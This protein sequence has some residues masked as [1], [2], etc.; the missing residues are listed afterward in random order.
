MDQLSAS[1]KKKVLIVEDESVV[2]L[3][4]RR[5]L[6]SLGYHVVGCAT[7]GNRAI[8][9]IKNEPP[10]V[11]LMDIK[12]KGD[13]DGLDTARLV[14]NQW[15]IPVVYVTAYAD[16]ETIQRAKITNSFGYVLKPFQDR[17]ISV[18]VEMA[19]F[20]H[21]MQQEL[22]EARIRAE[23]ADR[24][25]S[26]FLA[27]ISHELRTPL[28]SI[29]GMA[30]LSIDMCENSLQQDY[31]VILRK[32]AG[33]LLDIINNILSFI[34]YNSDEIAVENVRYDFSGLLR[35]VA[36]S[37]YTK[38]VEKGLD[39]NIWEE[40][41]VNSSLI[42]DAQKLWQILFVLL[43]N[44]VKFTPAGSIEFGI[45]VKETDPATAELN[46]IIEDT[47]IGIQGDDLERIFE[48]FTQGD[49]S[50]T[51]R[52]SGTGIGL[53]LAKS[54]LTRL[55]GSIRVESEQGAGTTF[56]IKLPQGYS[57]ELVV[58]NP[59]MVPAG[60]R[61]VI[62][63][64][65]DR[66]REILEQYLKDAG[67]TAVS[68]RSFPEILDK[69]PSLIKNNWVCLMHADQIN[70]G[71]FRDFI[72]TRSPKLDEFIKSARF[73]IMTKSGE[74]DLND[75]IERGVI[76]ERLKLPILRKDLN[77]AILRVMSRSTDEKK[78]ALSF[79]I[80]RTDNPLRILLVEDNAINRLVNSKMLLR[81]GHFVSVAE[82]GIQALDMLKKEKYE[83]VLMDIQMPVMDGYETTKKIRGGAEKNIPRDIPIVALT[84]HALEEEEQKSMAA[85]M[86]GFLTKPFTPE[87][88]EK[89]L[90]KASKGEPVFNTEK[91][92]PAGSEDFYK[93]LENAENQI[94]EEAWSVLKGTLHELKVLGA[95]IPD[96][97][98]SIQEYI[99]RFQL[100]IR[101]RNAESAM[102]L[103][104]NLKE[105]VQ[106]NNNVR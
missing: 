19:I 47:G 101:K 81:M 24:M 96:D 76:F 25:K 45:S 66:Q 83:L 95:N 50:R 75:Y 70:N 21:Q 84:A 106:K 54:L 67:C 15:D 68:C 12:L 63:S 17:E 35:K 2:A 78:Q 13:I 85:G 60:T 104:T 30:D 49:G 23:A 58:S 43:D 97:N 41:T 80:I 4:I 93:K 51:R 53:A 99:F 29:I 79:S 28:N 8:E 31:L 72:S 62:I 82:N 27:N 86:N 89:T 92:S 59:P 74:G 1:S 90:M 39:F 26:D 22:N 52:F 9:F 69:V 5:R 34:K 32:S 61:G 91:Q 37:V 46:F 87:N 88:L 3:D 103:L 48:P 102:E 33:L 94:K 105:L 40:N 98:G 100:L 73:L 77:A 71:T 6:E 16:M 38:A 44:A 55:M 7:S 56:S 64:Q 65:S 20:K 36:D 14:R 18:A 42:G 11:I 10:D 57:D